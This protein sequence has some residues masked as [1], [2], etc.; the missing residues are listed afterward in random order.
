MGKPPQIIQPRPAQGFVIH[1]KTER[2]DQM[3]LTARI[4]AQTDD[5]AGV[6]GDFRLK[7]NEGKHLFSVLKRVTV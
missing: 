6:G 4:G 2:L 1:A 5:I 7:E 3:Q